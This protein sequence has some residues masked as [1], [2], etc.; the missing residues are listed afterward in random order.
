MGMTPYSYSSCIFSCNTQRK[1]GPIEMPAAE[2]IAKEQIFLGS[3]DIFTV[4][5]EHL[6]RRQVKGSVSGLLRHMLGTRTSDERLRVQ[7][8]LPHPVERILI[9]VCR[10]PHLPASCSA[11]RPSLFAARLPMPCQSQTQRLV[12]VRAMFKPFRCLLYIPDSENLRT[13]FSGSRV[14]ETLGR[15]PVYGSYQATSYSGAANICARARIRRSKQ[16]NCPLALW[17]KAWQVNRRRIVNP[18]TWSQTYSGS[19]AICWA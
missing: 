14:P 15:F 11:H 6:V 18:S 4:C 8:L 16:A 9:H 12:D 2:C 10:T 1:F 13:A 7:S 17:C 5:L 3:A 19:L